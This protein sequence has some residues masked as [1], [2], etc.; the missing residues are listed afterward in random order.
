MVLAQNKPAEQ[1]EEE[2]PLMFQFRPPAP[3]IT[4]KGG[5]EFTPVP[6]QKPMSKEEK[7]KLIAQL[8]KKLGRTL[9]EK[10]KAK[11]EQLD[12]SLLKLDPSLLV[13]LSSRNVLAGTGDPQGPPAGLAERAGASE[14]PLAL[15]LADL[16]KD[17]Y[18]LIDWATAIKTGKIK[19]K[20]CIDPP[21]KCRPM[22]PF[23]L[24]IV[25]KAKSKF[26]PDVVFPHY[27]HTLWL[28]CTNC[29]PKIFKM[30]AGG[31]P[32]MHMT[33]IAAGEYCG[34]CHNRVAFPLA[35]CPRCHVKPK[36]TSQ[37]ATPTGGGG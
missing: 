5:T 7:R 24:D 22:P 27:T 15:E 4:P 32:E 8:E 33:K 26:M 19:P 23:N 17:R 3:L 9:P 2:K 18:G 14:H 35:D 13:Y 30:K 37:A 16:P 10:V 1:R 31:N 21:P 36:E 29:H 6:L 25:I 12:P 34:R 20:D 28:T 11:L